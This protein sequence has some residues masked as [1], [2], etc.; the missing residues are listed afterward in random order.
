MSIP[1]RPVLPPK[2]PSPAPHSQ[3]HLPKLQTDLTSK[4]AARP[5]ETGAVSPAGSF[6]S[7]LS[8]YSRSS[9]GESNAKYSDGL[10][11]QR[12]SESTLSPEAHDDGAKSWKTAKDNFAPL[13]TIPQ[14]AGTP[15]P[16]FPPRQQSLTSRKALPRTPAPAQN[17]PPPPTPKKDSIYVAK[18]ESPAN[19]VTETS[20][21]WRRRSIKTD[22]PIQVPDLHLASLSHGST[23]SSQTSSQNNILRTAPLALGA[24][25]LS[26][27]GLKP[28]AAEN[29]TLSARPWQPPPR[30]YVSPVDEGHSPEPQ[31][32]STP[33]ANPFKPYTP[34]GEQSQTFSA[35]AAKRTN[36]D[37]ASAHT[38]AQEDHD[39]TMGGK[40]SKIK[41]Q[42]SNLGLSRLSR[43][44]EQQQKQLPAPARLQKPQPQQQTQMTPQYDQ[45]PVS[46][47]EGPRL[48]TPDYQKQ[49][50]R[51]G[52][53][54]T[55]V[56]PM[57]PAAPPTPPQEDTSKLQTQTKAPIQR[58][59]IGAAAPLRP[60]QS[61]PQLITNNSP[62]MS[63]GAPSPLPPP[64]VRDFAPSPGPPGSPGS[65]YG[66]G[67]RRFPGPRPGPAYR[68]VITDF[69]ELREE[70]LP[71]PDPRA[72][73][74]PRT[75]VEPAA[76]DAIF[77][78]FPIGRSHMD[79]HIGHRIMKPSRNTA[80]A[81]AC[82][83][84]GVADRG[85]RWACA[86]C[87]VRVCAGC[88]RSLNANGRS[89]PRLLEQLEQQEMRSPGMGSSGMRS[90]GVE[91]E[92]GVAA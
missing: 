10:A 76:P 56:S 33:S 85:D 90:P 75:V 22:R 18:A 63:T 50:V 35:P 21:I 19:S 24:G 84:C 11:S 70:D 8:A 66:G 6:G 20:P 57:S 46:P 39:D 9:A 30:T 4:P 17:E 80:Y 91:V 5:Q 59:A 32:Q 67:P 83:T 54:E 89:L 3:Q 64:S 48:P 1:R 87:H 61:L 92:A 47:L 42:M 72:L 27:Q 51:P 88:F 55:V 44:K 2:Q 31:S 7:L 16:Q 23:A 26:S 79:C 13:P 34:P 74:F 71:P 36:D 49:D 73:Y 81:L 65:Y 78:P 58:K 77:Q 68:P 45:Q 60:A 25:T 37:A 28:A 52:V 86:A 53:S 15:Q 82:Q 43:E 14:E 29:A 12:N 38:T 62:P 41:A 40:Q 69:R